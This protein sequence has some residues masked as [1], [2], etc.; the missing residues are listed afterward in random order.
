MM[1]AVEWKSQKNSPKYQQVSRERT[2]LGGITSPPRRSPAMDRERMRTL[3]DKLDP[4]QW[5]SQA[6]RLLH[7]YVLNDGP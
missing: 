5:T 1:S 3:S 6:R 4:V 7:K 2:M